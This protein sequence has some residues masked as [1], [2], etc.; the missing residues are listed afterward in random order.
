MLISA[1]ILDTACMSVCKY[2][3]AYLWAAETVLHFMRG[4]ERLTGPKVRGFS[5]KTLYSLFLFYDY[6]ECVVGSTVL[7]LNCSPAERE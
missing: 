1:C 3:T 7:E 5:A 4:S 2:G 6:K